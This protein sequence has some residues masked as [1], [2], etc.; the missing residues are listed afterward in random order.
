M[1]TQLSALYLYEERRSENDQLV[2]VTRFDENGNIVNHIDYR[3]KKID[4]SFDSSGNLLRR[5]VEEIGENGE[6]LNSWEST[7]EYDDKGNRL[8]YVYNQTNN[9]DYTINVGFT[10]KYFY[11]KKT[12]RC[13]KEKKGRKIIRYYE[14]DEKGNRTDEFHYF[15][16][17]LESRYENK[18]R[19]GLLFEEKSFFGEKGELG[20]IKKYKYNEQ[21]REIESNQFF[22][23]GVLY[24]QVLTF[25]DENNIETKQQIFQITPAEEGLQRNLYW[26]KENRKS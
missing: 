18:Y 15:E 22:G 19:K 7:Y 25:Y 11:D 2:D 16:G 26:K 17:R 13:I 24:K 5:F 23:N 20:W 14:Y 10:I 12:N 1:E 8:K 3:N 6:V 21:N 4:K 9:V